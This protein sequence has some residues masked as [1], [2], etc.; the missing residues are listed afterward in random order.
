MSYS[1]WSLIHLNRTSALNIPRLVLLPHISVEEFLLYCC[2][3]FLKHI[4]SPVNYR[5]ERRIWKPL[6]TFAKIL[7]GTTYI[8]VSTLTCFHFDLKI[9]LRYA[10]AIYFQKC[11]MNFVEALVHSVIFLLL[12]S[13]A[14]ILEHRRY[15]WS[16]I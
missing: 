12:Q 11:N 15:A 10:Q 5:F 2:S 9:C 13:N 7:L 3:F 1:T 16:Y 14:Q 4:Q 8:C 6:T